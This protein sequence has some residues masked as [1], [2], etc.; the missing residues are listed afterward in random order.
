M[1]NKNKKPWLHKNG[2]IKSDE[3]IK[4]ICHAWTAEQWNEYLSLFEREQAEYLL[5]QPQEV[6]SLSNDDYFNLFVSLMQ[7]DQYSHLKRSA[8]VCFRQ[9]SSR[10]R[11]VLEEL[12]IRHSTE[13][14]AARNLEISRVTLRRAKTR[15]LDK[16][17]EVLYSGGLKKAT[18]I[19]AAQMLPKLPSQTIGS[20]E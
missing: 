8:Q 2:K 11:Q 12:Y 14:E 5:I 16:I 9:L 7:Q 15:A 1:K 6:D 19:S 3:E 17:R 4:K 13:R 10:E 18:K 20:N